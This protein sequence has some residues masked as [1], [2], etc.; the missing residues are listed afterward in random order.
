MARAS[1]P[2]FLRDDR[3][4]ILPRRPSTRP[5]K[6]ETSR[7]RTGSESVIGLDDIPE[8]PRARARPLW[9][10][11][12]SRDCAGGRRGKREVRGEEGYLPLL[13]VSGWAG[14][15]RHWRHWCTA[16]SLEM[17]K[18]RG[19]SMMNRVGFGMTRKQLLSGTAGTV[20]VT[21]TE[22]FWSVGAQAGSERYQITSPASHYVRTGFG[23]HGWKAQEAVVHVRPSE[24]ENST[25]TTLS[26]RRRSRSTTE[27][28][29]TA[30]HWSLARQS[31]P[32]LISKREH[33]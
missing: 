4:S 8:V 26:M 27:Q 17:F 29:S 15:W 6:R 1:H 21:V 5:K 28:P 31:S 30:S 33:P 20:T 14:V 3:C 16:E 18:R 19:E 25:V 32:L 23:L 11:A 12:T 7:K 10:E 2:S 24:A 13:V 9:V 22:P